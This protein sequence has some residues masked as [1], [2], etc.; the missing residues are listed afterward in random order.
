[1][2]KKPVFI[3]LFQNG[4]PCG[5]SNNFFLSLFLVYYMYAH[6][7]A[8]KGFCGTAADQSYA[9]GIM[10]FHYCLLE[11]YVRVFAVHL[12]CTQNTKRTHSKANENKIERRKKKIQETTTITTKTTEKLA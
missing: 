7:Y 11:V 5:I 6:R 4:I 12:K 10:D 9:H 8:V 3:G 1:M 2:N